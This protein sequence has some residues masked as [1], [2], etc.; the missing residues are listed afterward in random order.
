[1]SVTHGSVP[2]DMSFLARASD[3]SCAFAS[4]SVQ[5]LSDLAV[6][7]N[8]TISISYHV[9][10]TSQCSKVPTLQ[11]VSVSSAELPLGQTPA[12]LA[13]VDCST[14]PDTTSIAALRS[15]AN[16]KNPV[17][18]YVPLPETGV[19][20]QYY[21]SREAPDYLLI[22]QHHLALPIEFAP[23]FW[24]SSASILILVF[25]QKMGFIRNLYLE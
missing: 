5:C 10:D 20:Q 8:K 15:E 2:Q 25:A 23:I 7:S 13:T 4:S 21:V 16:T 24:L 14:E 12:V 11:H 18:A 22:P 17:V 9:T 6:G 1:M 19:E 3:A